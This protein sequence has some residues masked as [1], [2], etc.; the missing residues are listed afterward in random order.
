V[1]RSGDP[2]G[3]GVAV[4]DLR[5]G[6]VADRA[7]IGRDAI[8]VH[9]QPVRSASYS[10]DGDYLVTADDGGRLLYWDAGTGQLENARYGRLAT[11]APDEPVVLVSDADSDLTLVVVGDYRRGVGRWVRWSVSPSRRARDTL[12]RV[13]RRGK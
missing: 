2:G 5:T 9:V 8:P 13:P 7:F 4:F 6:V 10:P 1:W 12:C 3:A 11:Y